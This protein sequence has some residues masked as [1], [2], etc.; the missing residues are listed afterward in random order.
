MFTFLRDHALQRWTKK[1]TQELEVVARLTWVGFKVLFVERFMLKYQKLHE[2]MNLV[3]KTHTG[4][5]KAY[6]RD[7]K[8]QI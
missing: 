8:V 3:Q 1:K 4:S 7:F 6:V 5:L 2:G